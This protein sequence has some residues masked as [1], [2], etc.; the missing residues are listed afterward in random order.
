MIRRYRIFALF[1]ILAGAGG[2]SAGHPGDGETPIADLVLQNGRIH[3]LNEA[4]A[5]VSAVAVLDG[6]IVAVGDDS[7]VASFVGDSTQIIDLEGKTAIP[8]IID[9]HIH[10]MGFGLHT[11]QHVMFSTGEFIT[12]DDMLRKIGERARNTAPG[13]WIY[14]RG[15]Y[16]YDFVAEGRLPNRA[17]LDTVTPDNPVFINMQGH[18]GVVN[19]A[20]IELSGVKSDTPDPPNGVF[21]R[22]PETGELDGTLYEFPAFTP[23][24]RHIPPHSFDARV[25]A[26]RRANEEF[27]RFGITSVVNLWALPDN[28]DVL[29]HLEDL[30][31]M[32]ARWSMVYKLAPEDFVGKSHDEVK[33]ILTAYGLPATER[34]EWTSVDGIKIIYD[35]FAEAAYMHD[36]YMEDI[37]GSGW[38]GVAFWDLDSMRTV[39]EVCAANDIQVFVHVAGDKALDDVLDVIESVDERYSIAGRRWTLEH[40]STEPTE[41]NI[42]QVR[43]LELVVSTQQAMG[44][45]IGKT[46]RQQWGEARGATFAPNKSWLAALGHPYVKA[47]SDNRPID[48]YIGFWSYLARQDVDGRVGRP[49]QILGRNDVL[50]MYTANGA[51]GI[52]AEGSRG[53]IEVGKRADIV[54]LSDDILAIPI[55]E[56]RKIS[57]ILT[58]ANGRIVFRGDKKAATSD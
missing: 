11:T 57:P 43:A 13:E 18:I 6:N 46:F 16:S 22:D 10:A 54:V 36:T 47:G 19:S 42:E 40:A 44:W 3:T 9:S 5:T 28:L 49:D 2:C 41:G 26:V 35:G 51:Y 23:F 31:E 38:H 30:N 24:L 39:M 33:A 17:E 25:E 8:G 50:R 34:S 1:S 55:D 32:T 14:V 4:A 58:I 27:A 12:V 21:V 45:S 37:F 48:P 56:V 15:P 52:F 20:A 7:R 53:S 29:R